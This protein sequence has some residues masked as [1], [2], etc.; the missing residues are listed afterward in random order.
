MSRLA[1]RF[2]HN[3]QQATARDGLA[4]T[5]D[6]IA[7]VAPS[8]FATES[9]ESRSHRYAMIPT[10]AVL[11][12]LRREGFAP[13]MAGQSRSRVEGKSEFTKHMLRLRHVDALST[14]PDVN[15]VIIVNSHD[16]TSAYQML[17]GVFR[18]V[19][20]NG[21][22]CG[23]V[24]EDI[25]IK[26]AGTVVQDVIEGA[27]RI[28]AGFGAVD[29][30]KDAMKSLRLSSG[31]AR[32]FAEAALAIRY[33]DAI[34]TDGVPVTVEQVLRPRRVEDRDDSL[35]TTFQRA[36]EALVQGGLHGRTRDANGRTRRSTTRPINGIDGNVALNRGLWILAERM[37]ELHASS[38]AA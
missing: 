1:T 31:E 7:R 13:F 10:S 27:H 24:T 23:T 25:R 2:G 36:Q 3:R 26:H 34:D 32:A 20:M 38:V 4:L 35:W 14:G 17:S 11:D 21:M 6:Q 16:G 18:H 30:S 15:E 19:C 29:A 5:D 37:R 28:L 12:G 9:H 8:V 22:I 33:P